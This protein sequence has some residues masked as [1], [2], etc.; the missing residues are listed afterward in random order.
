[1]QEDTLPVTQKKR[2]TI[3]LGM[4]VTLLVAA[5]VSVLCL[6]ARLRHSFPVMFRLLAASPERQEEI[7]RQE[8]R[9]TDTGCSLYRWALIPCSNTTNRSVLVEAA[10]LKY[11]I[12]PADKQNCYEYVF[13]SLADTNETEEVRLLAAG[14]ICYMDLD[15]DRTLRLLSDLA[16]SEPKGSCIR[17]GVLEAIWHMGRNVTNAALIAQH[18]KWWAEEYENEIPKG[19]PGSGLNNQEARGARLE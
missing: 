15:I 11:A 16:G 17:R 5:F 4:G 12:S 8:R 6:D 3:W 2:K 19:T 7:L 18:E 14:Y 1:M 13:Q 10:V 9:L